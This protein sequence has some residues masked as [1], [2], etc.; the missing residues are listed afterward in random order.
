MRYQVSDGKELQ[1]I[2]E[3]MMDHCLAPDT[4]SGAGIGC[5]NMTVLI[6]AL[7]HGRT[8]EEW[9]TW[10]TERVKTE[11]GY[12]TPATLPQLYAQSRINSFKA[13]KEAMES[14]D[15]TWSDKEESSTGSFLQN[16]GLGG[17]ARVLGSTGGISFHP[18]S[19]VLSDSGHTLMFGD[20]D[21]D[22]DDSDE[23]SGDDAEKA[24]GAS[25]GSFF[26]DTSGHGTV[27]GETGPD[28]TDNLRNRFEEFDQEMKEDEKDSGG[29]S[30]MKEAPATEPIPNGAANVSDEAPPVAKV[31]GLLDGT[32]DPLVKSA[33]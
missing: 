27:E 21:D 22:G 32:E 33:A 6:I 26:G 9:Y 23:D 1:E 31:E 25:S 8:K 16:A 20:D 12:K 14:R 29:D 18:G 24:E 4:S 7:L 30:P 28:S 2:G 10:V 5:D 11:H 3:M 17:F 15:K 19:G 13:R